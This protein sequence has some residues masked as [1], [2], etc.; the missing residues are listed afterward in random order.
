VALIGFFAVNSSW[1]LVGVGVWTLFFNLMSIRAIRHGRNPWWNRTPE[2]YLLR[3]RPA[4]S[5]PRR[6]PDEAVIA[7]WRRQRRDRHS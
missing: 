4:N 1:P 6:L 7:R 2:D 3:P 5:T